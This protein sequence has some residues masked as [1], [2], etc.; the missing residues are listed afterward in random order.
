MEIIASPAAIL[1]ATTPLFALLLAAA[2]LREPLTDRRLLDEL[3]GLLGVVVLVGLGPLTLDLGLILAVAASQLAA[4]LY[5]A[6]GVHAKTRFAS[7]TRSSRPLPYA[8][9][10][11][12]GSRRGIESSPPFRSP[13]R[14]PRLS[15]HHQAR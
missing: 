13:A 10:A 14:S 9:S 12:T 11:T 6:G 4:L 7:T 8:G 5:V 3:L 2:R 15:H 1:D